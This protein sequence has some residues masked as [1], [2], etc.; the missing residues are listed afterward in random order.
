MNALRVRGLLYDVD[1]CEGWEGR[2]VV[3][4]AFAGGRR[5]GGR[6]RRRGSRVTRS[7]R[8]AGASWRVSEMRV[9]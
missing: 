1:V 9:E 6:R 4:A 8:P 2:R 5:R 7:L 3:A